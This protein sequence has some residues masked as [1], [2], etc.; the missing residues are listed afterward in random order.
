MTDPSYT[1]DLTFRRL[2][3]ASN[4]DSTAAI[5]RATS[6][7]AP[8]LVR[9]DLWQ[10]VARRERST[11]FIRVDKIRWSISH[12]QRNQSRAPINPELQTGSK[13]LAKGHFKPRRQ[14]FRSRVQDTDRRV[15]SSFLF[16]IAATLRKALHGR[17]LFH[18]RSQ[19]MLN[20]LHLSIEFDTKE[21]THDNEDLILVGVR[22][23]DRH[24]ALYPIV[25][26]PSSSI[27]TNFLLISS[28]ELESLPVYSAKEDRELPGYFETEPVIH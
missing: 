4:L 26:H 8:L 19:H 2:Y 11:T 5:P 28:P 23:G 17:R 1:D 20:D 27:D 6:L 16:D 12:P 13:V 9:L 15:G 18:G 7:D 24:G 25:V 22:Q 3:P 14:D 10:K 21:V